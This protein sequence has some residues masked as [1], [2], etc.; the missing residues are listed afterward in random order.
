MN[1]PRCWQPWVC[2][3]PS[4]YKDNKGK[5]LWKWTSD[6]EHEVCPNCGLIAHA[7]WW[8]EE[9]MLQPP[10][11][12]HHLPDKRGPWLVAHIKS[13]PMMRSKAVRSL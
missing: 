12:H 9:E 7:D 13:R 6:G 2:G 4:C 3:C 1:C 10:Q 5:M 8:F 11:E